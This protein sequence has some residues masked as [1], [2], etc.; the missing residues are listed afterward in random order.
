[1]VCKIYH[2]CKLV[3]ADL[4]EYNILYHDSHLYI[5]DVSQSVKHD[6]PHAFD[7]LRNDAKNVEEYF[8][9]REVETLGLEG[10]E[11]VTREVF[12]ADWK[13]DL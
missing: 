10:F 13:T 1:M 2:E 7:F 9:R 11:F 8:R 12:D 4:S 5:I 3:H 6:H